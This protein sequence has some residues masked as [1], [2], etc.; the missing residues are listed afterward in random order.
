[1]DFNALLQAIKCCLA[2]NKPVKGT[3]KAYDIPRSSLQRYVKKVAAQFDDISSVE[4][5]VLLEFVR[6]CS[7]R[8]PSNMVSLLFAFFASSAS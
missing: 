4:D 2:D 5:G 3:A 6:D 1:M 8:R 7:Q